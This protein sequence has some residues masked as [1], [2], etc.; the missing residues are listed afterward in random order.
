MKEKT[1]KNR[2]TGKPEKAKPFGKG[3]LIPSWPQQKKQVKIH[4]LFLLIN[5]KGDYKWARGSGLACPCSSSGQP[6]R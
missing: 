2:E 3:V 6:C 4:L 5:P 1:W